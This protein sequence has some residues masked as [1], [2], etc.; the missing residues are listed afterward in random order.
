M[1][2]NEICIWQLWFDSFEK[3]YRH[4][5]N[6]LLR[7]VDDRPKRDFCYTYDN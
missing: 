4:T 6:D 1:E 3:K 5:Q 7:V 2:W